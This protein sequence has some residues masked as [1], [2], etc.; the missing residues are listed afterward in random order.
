MNVPQAESL[1][2]DTRYGWIAGP[3]LTMATPA[4]DKPRRKTK[5]DVRPFDVRLN[6]QFTFIPKGAGEGLR[7]LSALSIISF[8][9][10]ACPT[11]FIS[12]PSRST[13]SRCF[14]EFQIPYPARV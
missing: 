2:E 1:V 7:T 13:S 11:P 5:D 12:S 8:H 14:V 4:Y 9:A 10:A 6:H 3:S